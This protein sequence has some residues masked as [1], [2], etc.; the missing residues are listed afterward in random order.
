M[1]RSLNCPYVP[2]D[3]AGVADLAPQRV[4]SRRRAHLQSKMGRDHPTIVIIPI[5]SRLRATRPVDPWGGR[6]RLC[7]GSSSFVPRLS[8]FVPRVE[9]VCAAGRV[10][11]CRGPSLFVPRAG[12]SAPS[13]RKPLLIHS[14]GLPRST[15]GARFARPSL[16][17]IE[18]TA[19]LALGIQARRGN[20]RGRRHDRHRWHVGGVCSGNPRAVAPGRFVDP[21]TLPQRVFG[22]P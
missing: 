14:R 1:T 17:S 10:R 3:P 20:A 15:Q 13:G 6:V 21:G 7:R 18:K 12:K 5:W 11:L 16:D 9:F 4:R 19:G 8:S 2:I 22:L